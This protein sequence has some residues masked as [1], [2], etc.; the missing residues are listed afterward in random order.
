[1]ETRI[2]TIR[3]S[4]KMTQADLANMSGVSIRMIQ[5]YEQRDRNITKNRV[6]DVPPCGFLLHATRNATRN[7][8][9][10]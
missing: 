9:F 2:K 1:M 8:V 10:Y 7:S 6:K 4:R 3:E 5:K